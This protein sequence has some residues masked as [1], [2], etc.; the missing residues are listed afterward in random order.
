MTG[1]CPAPAGGLSGRLSQE[2]YVSTSASMSGELIAP[3]DP[4]M[5]SGT[6]ECLQVTHSQLLLHAAA[7][8]GLTRRLSLCLSL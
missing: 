8:E 4:H 2:G 3:R 7:Q 6:V 1:M 5:G